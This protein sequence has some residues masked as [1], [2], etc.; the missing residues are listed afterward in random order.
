VQGTLVL[1]HPGAPLEDRPLAMLR[2][3]AIYDYHTDH[4]GTPHA[5]TDQ[6]RKYKGWSGKEKAAP[7]MS[8]KSRLTG[9]SKKSPADGLGKSPGR[10][11]L[12]G[13]WLLL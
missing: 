2:G 8:E 13:T 11:R 1:E 6:R 4:L 3:G 12:A 10:Q 5:L 9:K 7:M